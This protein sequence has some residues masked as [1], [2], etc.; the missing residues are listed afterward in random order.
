MLKHKT[1]LQRFL[2]FLNYV[3]NFY[4][5]CAS[6]RKILNKRLGKNPPDW[7]NIH[8]KA[9]Q[10]IKA[11]VKSLP[12]LYVADDQAFNIVESDASNVGWGGVL[13][14]RIGKEE[15]V[16]Q[17]ASGALNLA[18]QNY[19]VIEREV[20]AAWNCI[21]KFEV[22]LINK[23][24][25]L[26]TDASAMQ[27]VLTKNI[28]KAGE[29]KFA[30]WQALFAN[31]DLSVEHIKG[32]DNSLP[33][34]LSR[35]YIE[36]KEAQ[37]LVI[38]T[39]WEQEHKRETMRIIPDE[40]EWE[41]YKRDWKP[42][43]KLRNT[44]V[45]DANLQPHMDLQLYVPERKVY[46]KGRTWIH[47]M[48]YD[49][50]RRNAELA[51]KALEQNFHNIATIWQYGGKDT[52]IYEKHVCIYH[53]RDLWNEPGHRKTHMA[54]RW[55]RNDPMIMFPDTVFDFADY[56]RLWWQFL[57]VDDQTETHYTRLKFSTVGHYQ[58]YQQNQWL[59][60]WWKD[61][62]VN[63]TTMNPVENEKY[64]RNMGKPCIMDCN[65]ACNHPVY[66]TV[67]QMTDN[68]W[69]TYKDAPYNNSLEEY[70]RICFI[71]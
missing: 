4:Q 16:V 3:S 1:Q 62:G 19:Y 7:S 58:G 20:K 43:W 56:K 47:E 2:G 28:K 60:E 13:K 12:I 23:P 9:V 68:E 54:A 32:K 26:R 67:K 50:A 64:C 69:T 53:T 55:P 46:P 57:N 11:K 30:R 29:A 27:K 70:M 44:K 25:L 14:Q 49:K 34:F 51:R 48:I 36:Q 71:L 63:K 35:G 39:E 61:Y 5:D 10:K 41:T 24:F 37:V 18:K 22:Y 31:F 40:L 15:Q 42:T 17:F 52:G 59:R 45:M 33:D 6:D 21:R 38:V 66:H 8:T 65:T